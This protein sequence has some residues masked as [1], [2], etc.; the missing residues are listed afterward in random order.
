MMESLQGRLIFGRTTRLRPLAPGP[1]ARGRREA[2]RLQRPDGAVLEGWSSWPVEGPAVG[3]LL[4]F[5]GRNENVAWAPD[6]ASYNPGWAIHAFNYR[7]CGRSTGRPCERHAN[8]DAQ[9]ILDFVAARQG[10]TTL[11]IAGRS[12]GTAIALSL[13]ARAQPSTLVLLSPFTSV[14]GVLRTRRLGR[15]GAALV[16]QRFDCR[17]PAASHGKATLLLL[18]EGDTAISQAQSRALCA[19]LPTPPAVREIAGT[20]HRSLPRSAGAQHAIA[21]FLAGAEAPAA[22]PTLLAAIG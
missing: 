3:A 20:T 18:A 1:H 14:P 6:M 15:I 7:G 10:I 5:G 9:A 12:L 19:C 8:D 22:P 11:A 4:Y 13:A 21:A 16:T 2:H 17:G